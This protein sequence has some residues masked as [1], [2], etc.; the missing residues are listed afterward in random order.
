VSDESGSTS[1]RKVAVIGAGTMGSG[2]AMVFA[3]AGIPVVLKETD[4]KALDRGLAIIRK[5]YANSVAK[6]R[7]AADEAERRIALITPT[8]SYEDCAEVDLVVEA[9]F[10]SMDIKKKVFTELDR[11]ISPTAILATNTSTLDID[12]IAA[13][14]TRPGLVI[15]LHFFSPANVMRLLEVVKGGATSSR[16]ISICMAMAKRIGKV[17]V[18]V[19]NCTGFVG[20]RMFFPYIREAQFLVE[21]G[22]AVEEV[23]R[24]LYDFGMAM[25][26]LATSDLTGL[27]V[28]LRIRKEHPQIL[29]ARD[30]QP[31]IE[32]LLCE[33]GHY[34][35]KT[36]SG[37]YVYD[38][39]RR[40]SRSPVTESLAQRVRKQPHANRNA[41]SPQEIVERTIYALINEGARILEEGYA[42]RSGDIDVVYTT[43]YGF[44]A[45][46]GGP[47]WYADTVGLLRIYNRILEWEG[48]F[49]ETWTPAPLLK[50][51]AENKQTFASLDRI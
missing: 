25:G 11:V 32:D 34:G 29:G 40:P 20:N 39:Y 18:L 17:G 12:A 51:L 43:G 37:W 30:R 1:I 36:G 6:G 4:G 48:R 8:L 46:R 45:H 49:G 35:Q 31:Q 41:V 19:G 9:V 16:V 33:G 14:T 15:G 44:P 13:V 3:N 22:A 5:N 42:L 47:M 27:D 2:I 26:P 24:A 38:E 21:E 7:I 50:K 28:L 23:D 10:E